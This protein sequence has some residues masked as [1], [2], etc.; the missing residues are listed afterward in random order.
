[1][2]EPAHEPPVLSAEQYL[3]FERDS[4]IKHEFLDGKVFAMAG[5]SLAHNRLC[6]NLGGLLYQHLRG[7][8]CAAYPADLRVFVESAGLYTYPDLSIVCGEPVLAGGPGL[9]T[10]TNPKVLIEV[11]SASTEDYDRGRKFFF[12]RSMASLD[13]YV[14][15]AQDRAHVESFTRHPDGQWRLS[16]WTELG[17]ELELPSIGVRLALADIYEGVLSS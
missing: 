16:E 6:A 4:E 7:G 3:E 1:M 2:A 5:S 9:D 15:V 10:L 12:Y 14:L 17:D 13:T 11:L 8:P